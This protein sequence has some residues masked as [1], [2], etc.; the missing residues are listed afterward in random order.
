[1]EVMKMETQDLMRLLH[2][3]YYPFSLFSEHRFNEVTE[4][5]RTFKLKQ[6]EAI[7]LKLGNKDYSYLM[8]GTA[9]AILDDAEQGLIKA[10]EKKGKP[11]NLQSISGVVR[12][13]AD[14]DCIICHVDGETIDHLLCWDGLGTALVQDDADIRDQIG[15]MRNS[16]AFHELPP[17]CVEEAL[18]RMKAINVKEGEEVV[19]QGEPGSVFYTIKA[20]R[21]EVWVLDEFEDEPQKVNE[22]GEGDS[23]GEYALITEKHRSATVRMM[24]DGVLLALEQA[25]FMELFF[26]QMVREVDAKISKALMNSGYE[27]VDVRYEEEHEEIHI[28][29]STPVPLHEM[30]QGMSDFSNDRK[31]VV[32]CRSGIRSRVAAL[33]M[34]QHGLEAVSLKGGI[35]DW[36]F[37][38]QGLSIRS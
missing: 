20:G 38:K 24:D 14:E 27:L 16:L 4:F 11:L 8:A 21:A 28:P 26:S 29:G 23:F 6:S 31:Y 9:K 3:D 1:M 25:D 13:Y 5:I 15:S 7:E 18:R 33:L 36:P 12:F 32:Y 22:L 34:S 19:R 10:E 35:L 37:E 2:K 17:E 30:R